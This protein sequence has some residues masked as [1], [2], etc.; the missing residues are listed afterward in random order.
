MSNNPSPTTNRRVA[1][2]VAGGILFA[3]IAGLGVWQLSTP[4]NN[5]EVMKSVPLNAT[6]TCSSPAQHS[7]S[8][9]TVVPTETNSGSSPQVVPP[10][11]V[12]SEDPFLAPHAWVSPAPAAAAPTSVYRPVNPGSPVPSATQTTPNGG[13]K[14]PIP[15]VLHHLQIPSNIPGIPGSQGHQQSGAGNQSPTPESPQ[16]SPTPSKPDIL[17]GLG[18]ITI[19]HF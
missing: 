5:S 12:Y 8:R 2:F 9:T 13:H 14:G 11:T 7:S 4:H 10:T 18:S 19:S 16:L 17:P 1:V 15:E 6:D 3:G